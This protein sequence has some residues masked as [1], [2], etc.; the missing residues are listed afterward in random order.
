[1]PPAVSAAT[2]PM[3]LKGVE[4]ACGGL[5]RAGSCCWKH[6]LTHIAEQGCNLQQGYSA[7]AHYRASTGATAASI[8][9]AAPASAS[10]WAS[11]VTAAAAAGILRLLRPHHA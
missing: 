2:A 7:A 1:M 4:L 10:S 5:A 9:A 3:D 8:S 11:V 6:A